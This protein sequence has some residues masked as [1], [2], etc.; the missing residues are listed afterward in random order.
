MKEGEPEEDDDDDDDNKVYNEEDEEEDII[1][2]YEKEDHKKVKRGVV[3][4]DLLEDEVNPLWEDDNVEI[5]RSLKLKNNK[6]KRERRIRKRDGNGGKFKRTVTEAEDD[7]LDL[8]NVYWFEKQKYVQRHK[9]EFV[10]Y[11]MNNLLNNNMGKF[12]VFDGNIR[13]KRWIRSYKLE[14]EKKGQPINKQ[15]FYD[16][17][18]KL[19]NYEDVDDDNDLDL[20]EPPRKKYSR[21]SIFHDSYSDVSFDFDT[22]NFTDPFFYRQWHLYNNGTVSKHPGNDINVVPLWK[23]GI[24][25]TGVVVSVIDDGVEWTHE[26]IFPNW[27]I[28]SSYD[29]SLNSIYT[30]KKRLPKSDSHGTR[31]AGAIAAQPNSV[32]G[33][34]VAFGAKIAGERLISSMTTD[35]MEA[36][37]LNYKFQINDIYS[38]SWGP[39]DDGATVEGPGTLCNKALQNGVLKGRNGYGSIFIFASGNGGMYDDNC[40]FDGFANSVYTIAVGAIAHD[41]TKPFYSEVCSAQLA[42]TYSGDKKLSIT[43]TD[44]L[45]SDEDKHTKVKG[46]TS[47]HSGTSAA[48]PIAAGIIALMLSARPDLGWRDVQHIIVDNAVIIQPDDSGWQK[49]GAGRFVHHSFGFGKMDAEKL[50]NASIKHKILPVAP[51]K[52]DK[53]VSPRLTIPIDNELV[54]TTMELTEEEVGAIHSLEHVQITVKLPHKNRRY[55]TIKLISPSGTESLLATERSED[56]GNDGF[57]GWTFM[58]VFNW[59]ESPVGTWKLVINDSRKTENPDNIKWRLG[60]L[61]SWKIIVYGLCDEKYIEYDE[62]KR[63]FCNIQLANNDSIYDFINHDN[64]LILLMVITGSVLLYLL[65]LYF[66]KNTSSN[67]G[68]SSAKYI[69]LDNVEY[70]LGLTDN[71]IQKSSEEAMDHKSPSV[72]SDS[73]EFIAGPSKSTNVEATNDHPKNIKNDPL[74]ELKAKH[75]L[76]KSWSLN[77]LQERKASLYSTNEDN[78]P[79]AD[80][81]KFNFP[82]IPPMKGSS[83]KYSI[84]SNSREVQNGSHKETDNAKPLLKNIDQNKKSSL[85]RSFSTKLFTN[86]DDDKNKNIKKK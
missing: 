72:K 49:N 39:N 29:F 40:N 67:I 31:C 14:H 7:L 43:T 4:D 56:E 6:R 83:L 73:D 86:D 21:D 53:E 45:N 30:D 3:V 20:N 37:A 74:R 78:T 15:D 48:A 33:V 51:L 18:R 47:Y 77:N 84:E 1:E 52:F 13:R 11:D 80:D 71:V 55:L 19:N 62:E 36:T 26:D 79:I 24:N 10:A 63:P 76:V 23:R 50:V 2:K 57:N 38:N 60:K 5:Y 34:G 16:K 65:Y 68:S 17:L 22:L 61:M 85:K 41:N 46:C 8:S 66:F 28:D 58:T 25:G 35:S 59:G 82:K 9:R 69:P 27:N 44:I 42:V 12:N 81:K 32:C 75:N 64:I 70:E 54:E